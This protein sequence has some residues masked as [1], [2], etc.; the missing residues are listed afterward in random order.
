[1]AT[2]NEPEND[3]DLKR[4]SAELDSALSSLKKERAEAAKGMN[5]TGNMTGMAYAFRLSSEF[6][7]AILVGTAIGWLI[8]K[9]AGSSPWGLIFFLL[10]GFAAGI[11]NVLRS[12]GLIAVPKSERGTDWK[13]S[14]YDTTPPGNAWKDD[15]EDR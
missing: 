1:M 9:L 3:S 4:R 15:E 13:P 5:R 11:L 10:L 12:A 2:G 8:D 14:A 6:I 7:A